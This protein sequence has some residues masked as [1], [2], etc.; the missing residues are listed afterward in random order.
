MDLI[1][2][3]ESRET[4]KMQIRSIDAQKLAVRTN[5]YI[6]TFSSLT[7]LLLLATIIIMFSYVQKNKKYQQLLRRSKQSAETVA[8]AKER[9][10]ANMSHE[11]RTPMNAISG[12]SKVLMRSDLNSDQREQ[13]EIINKSSDH[14]LKLL[15]DILDFSK[16]RPRICEI[17][18]AR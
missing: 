4:V 16:L 11:I 18:C 5:E 6:M 7:F 14:L 12:F 15:N 9:F 8:K 2:R 10:F 1:G 3:L 17:C 13:V